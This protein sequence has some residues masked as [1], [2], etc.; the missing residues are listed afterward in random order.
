MKPTKTKKEARRTPQ[1]LKS[2]R[3]QSGDEI[4]T[5]RVKLLT[6]KELADLA[7]E[8]DF[9]DRQVEGECDINFRV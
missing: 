1:R 3:V 6:D 7:N 9:L 8:H 5:G 4:S 2:K